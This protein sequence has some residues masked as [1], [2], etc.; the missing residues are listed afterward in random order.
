MKTKLL[1]CF[2]EPATFERLR[3]QAFQERCSVSEVVR[4]AV[5]DYLAKR[6]LGRARK[7]GA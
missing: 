6:S 3:L 2:V 4:R 1:G 5:A 7:G